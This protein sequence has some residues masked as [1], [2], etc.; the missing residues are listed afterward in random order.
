MNK[1]TT[2][3]LFAAMLIT[4]SIPTKVPKVPQ[5]LITTYGYKSIHLAG[6]G[7][8]YYPVW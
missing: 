8:Q 5:E 1:L 3:T 7:I 4:G 6:V 2:K